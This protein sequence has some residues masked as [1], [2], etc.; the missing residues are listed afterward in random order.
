MEQGVCSIKL[1]EINML[2]VGF[3]QILNVS[4]RIPLSLYLSQSY[5]YE[6]KNIV[7]RL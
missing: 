4:Y 2:D 7:Y 5:S 1:L 6:Y 3:Y